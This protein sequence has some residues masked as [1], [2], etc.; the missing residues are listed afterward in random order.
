MSWK[1]LISDSCNLQFYIANIV[2]L[3]HVPYA[4]L[5]LGL[6]IYLV[7]L[8]LIVS[9]SGPWGVVKVAKG[10]VGY[11]G[12]SRFDTQQGEKSYLWKSKI[13]KC[14]FLGEWPSSQLSHKKLSENW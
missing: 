9:N 7:Q 13:K 11:L 4:T 1:K 6:I 14:Q 10:L 8:V 5:P 2:P 3:N 12:A